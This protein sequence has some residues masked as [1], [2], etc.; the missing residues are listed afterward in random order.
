MSEDIRTQVGDRIRELRNEK[1][2]SIRQLADL[3]GI[4]Y[5]N[6][7]AIENGK[8]NARLDTLQKLA[9]GLNIDIKYFFDF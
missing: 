8:Y 2:L 4:H 9:E 7:S 1:G 6:L 3:S 5:P